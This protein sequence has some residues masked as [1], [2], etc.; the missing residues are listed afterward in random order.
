MLYSANKAVLLIP[1][2]FLCCVFIAPSS[3][4]GQQSVIS[5]DEKPGFTLLSNDG[6]SPIILVDSDDWAGVI[7]TTVDLATDFGLVTGTN[8]T[9]SHSGTLTTNSNSTGLLIIVGTIGKSRLVDALVQE[10]KINVTET[11]GQWGAFHTRMVANI[12]DDIS[13]GLVI[14]GSD[15]RGAIYGIYDISA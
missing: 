1:L 4:L 13:A 5:F 12:T 8:G 14:A 2:L 7:R 11:Q 3:A 9:V 15:K 10:G 6:T